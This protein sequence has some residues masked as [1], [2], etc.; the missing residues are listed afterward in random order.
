MIKKVYRIQAY[1]SII[2]QYF[3][4]GVIDE[5]INEDMPEEDMN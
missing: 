1:D 3:C 4:I 2:C 5:N